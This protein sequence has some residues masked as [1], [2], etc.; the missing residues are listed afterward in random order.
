MA[1]D[2]PESEYSEFMVSE[3]Q[4]N[5]N[6]AE[7]PKSIATAVP[8]SSKSISDIKERSRIICGIIRLLLNRAPLTTRY[9]DIRAMVKSLTHDKISPLT[10]NCLIDEAKK[11]AESVFG[12]TLCDVK[13]PSGKREL[14]LK[15]S[16]AFP[17]HDLKITSTADHELRGFLLLMAP[18]LKAYT[19]G[20]PLDRLCEVM[21]KVGRGSLVPEGEAAESALAQS[22]RNARKRKEIKTS[23]ESFKSVSDYLVYAR[24][25][26]Y[27][28]IQTDNT[29]GTG[30]A[31]VVITP[32][33]RFILEFDQTAYL[34]Q[35]NILNVDANIKRSLGIFFE[36]G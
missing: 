10:V 31:T 29:R 22:L 7:L 25:L 35:F 9:E 2:D 14:F 23:V 21:R 8:I 27:I 5:E 16:L 4:A 3:H 30:L 36:S 1:V 26:G 13:L 15:Q 17:P 12:L 19:N 33:Y 24:D 11:Y 32:N 34:K 6:P 18:C 20:I 28:Q